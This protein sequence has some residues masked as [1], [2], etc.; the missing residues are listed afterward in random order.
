MIGS[1]S[2]QN[3]LNANGFYDSLV[4]QNIFYSYFQRHNQSIVCPVIKSIR[5]N[6]IPILDFLKS[7]FDTL[8]AAFCSVRIWKWM[9][10]LQKSLE[11]RGERNVCK[12]FCNYL[13]YVSA[14]K[15]LMPYC[16]ASRLSF[17]FTKST[18]NE[19]VSS[20]IFSSSA[21]TLSQVKQLLASKSMNV[22]GI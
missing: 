16:F 22:Y 6:Y 2:L 3:E 10:C 21:N 19:S 17:I 5:N 4:N 1:L 12:S 13:K 8:N 18:P 20:S 15:V 9:L 11:I 7:I 14:G